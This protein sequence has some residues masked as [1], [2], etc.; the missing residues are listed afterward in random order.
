MEVSVLPWQDHGCGNPDFSGAFRAPVA[1]PPFYISRSATAGIA[2][3]LSQPYIFL[4]RR[5][6]EALWFSLNCISTLLDPQFKLKWCNEVQCQ[7]VKEMA[8]AEMS[9][10]GET[11]DAK[12]L[13]DGSS[14][15]PPPKKTKMSKLFSFLQTLTRV[16]PTLILLKHEG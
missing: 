13:N 11:E 5:D 14:S 6:L 4:L 7:Q 16:G 15:P 1:E 10:L 2:K 12:D 9:L 3:V 8:F